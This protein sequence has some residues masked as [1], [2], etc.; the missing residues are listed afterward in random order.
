MDSQVIA[1]NIATSRSPADYRIVGELIA[2]M[3]R[4]DDPA[5]KKV[6]DSII[7]EL[8]KTG[9][10]AKMYDRWFMRPIPPKNVKLNAPVDPAPA[11]MRAP[12]TG[13]MTPESARMQ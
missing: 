1:G 9:E 12:S 4:K 7:R 5:F 13:P 2:I 8:I 11:S 3:L 6:V 10:L